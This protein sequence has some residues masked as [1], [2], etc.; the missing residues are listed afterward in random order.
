M[1]GTKLLT[2]MYNDLAN[3]ELDNQTKSMIAC[4]IVS[5]TIGHVATKGNE[6][7]LL[8]ECFIPIMRDYVK[9]M[10]TIK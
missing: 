5:M 8:E 1:N 4:A 9:N 10:P 2:K 3:A 6:E 7:R